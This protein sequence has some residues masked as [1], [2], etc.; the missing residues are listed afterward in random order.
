MSSNGPH[1]LA[2]ERAIL[3]A[4]LLDPNV[5][6]A[7]ADRLTPGDFFQ[8]IHAQLWDTITRQRR[9]GEPIDPVSLAAH[10][11]ECGDLVRIG[12]AAFL[13]TLMS[14]VPT[15]ANATHYARIVIDHA[16][17]RQVIRLGMELTQTAIMGD[18]TTSVVAKGRIILADAPES[19]WPALMPLSGHRTTRAFPIDALPGW[20]ADMVT[21]VAAF[22]QT[23]ADL[24]A[25]VALAA[26]STAAGGRTIFQVRPGWTE[27]A[28][29]FLVCVLP[30]GSRK[31]AVFA[32]MIRPLLEVEKTL[33]ERA[34]PLKV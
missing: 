28:N 1:D 4:C 8:P 34:E 20:L 19:V 24:A 15:A 17:R 25:T 27:P 22:T 11:A 29:L 10:L 5:V 21:T 2:A 16:R 31:S 13:H 26:L 18:D 3:G 33:I 14:S 30:P 7:L 6:D 9:A 23:P 32:A 12:G